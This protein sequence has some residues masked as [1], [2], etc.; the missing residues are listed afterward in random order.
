M[1][2]EKGKSLSK[3]FTL[4]GKKEGVLLCVNNSYSFNEFLESFKDLIGAENSFF[5]GGKIVGIEGIELSDEEKQEFISYI[6]E[7]D[8]VDLLSLDYA[9]VLEKETVSVETSIEAEEDSAVQDSL[10]MTDVK[11]AVLEKV[12]L[13]EEEFMADSLFFRGTVRSGVRLESEKNIVVIGDVNPGAELVAKSNIVV[14]GRLKGFAHAGADGSKDK[15]IAAWKL[16][17]T[18]I[19]IADYITMPP[20]GELEDIDYPEMALIEDDRVIIKSYQ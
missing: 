20:E 10:A 17:P 15:I 6:E 1:V 16:Q 5:V 18:Q 2:V 3:I 14:L 19:R 4:K 8:G 11:M 12:F 13:E 7:I 9:K